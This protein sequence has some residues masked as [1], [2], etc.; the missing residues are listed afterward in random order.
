MQIDFLFAPELPAEM[1]LGI[2]VSVTLLLAAV[3][4]FTYRRLFRTLPKTSAWI[5]ST[6]KLLAALLLL[7]LIFRPVIKFIDSESFDKTVLFMFDTSESMS[8]KDS[9]G[10][11]PRLQAVLRRINE[12]G[13][14]SNIED[15][16]NLRVYS[17]NADEEIHELE[18]IDD[19]SGIVPG[20]KYTQIVQSAHNILQNAGEEQVG[21]IVI[22]SDG[23]ENSPDFFRNKR[24]GTS[25]F[26]VG[27]G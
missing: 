20:G 1:R 25:I 17:F 3:L 15:S 27:V 24:L 23:V 14:K 2:S 18:N 9:V 8:I 7:I 13:I 21:A 26:T 5:I 16:F 11:L 19:L 4:Y 10:N 12:T 6:S 22:F